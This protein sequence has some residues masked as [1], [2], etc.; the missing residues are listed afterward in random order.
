MG[1]NFAS[2]LPGIP[3]E[4]G[5]TGPPGPKGEAGGSTGGVVYTRW[6]RKHCPQTTG[7]SE[8]Y[9]GIDRMLDIKDK[10]LDTNIACEHSMLVRHTYYIL[11]VILFLLYLHVLHDRK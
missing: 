4:A 1:N 3:G 9:S 11:K 2:G 10:V 8:L 5:P 6:G 7:T